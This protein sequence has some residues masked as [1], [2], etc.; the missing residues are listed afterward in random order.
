MPYYTLALIKKNLE[1]LPSDTSLDATFDNYG[2]ESDA[3]V[4]TLMGNT[5]ALSPV[6]TIITHASSNYA[7]GRYL[8]RISPEPGQTD[9][10]RQLIE[11][12]EK[13]V[14]GYIETLRRVMVF[15]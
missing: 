10:A 2:A 4:D 11:I 13:Q 15:G 8:Y 1:I 7:A 12:A 14:R 9:R 3:W 5:S 6:P